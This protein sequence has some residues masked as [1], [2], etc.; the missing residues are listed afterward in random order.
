MF[1]QENE[2]TDENIPEVKKAKSGEEVI[3]EP[4]TLGKLR[5]FRI[6]KATRKKLKERGVKFL[7]PI[8]YRTFDHVY[9]NAD[10]IGQ[11]STC[12]DVH[13]VSMGACLM[14]RVNYALGAY[15]LIGY[16]NRW[17]LTEWRCV[18]VPRWGC[19]LPCWHRWY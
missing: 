13:F 11:A 17:N 2:N 12:R 3:L 15:P 4:K 1:E 7:F 16:V 10:V 5:N 18:C 14:A 9:D 19:A 8:Q 6:S